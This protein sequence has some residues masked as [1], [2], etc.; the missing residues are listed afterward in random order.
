MGECE[1]EEGEACDYMDNDDRNIDIDVALSYIDDRI[2]DI[3]GQYQKDFEGGVSADTLGARFGGY[4]TFLPTYQRSPSIRSNPVA[5]HKVQSHGIQASSLDDQLVEGA[6]QN[7]TGSISETVSARPEAASRSAFPLRVAKPFPEDRLVKPQRSRECVSGYEPQKGPVNPSNQKMLKVRFKVGSDNCLPELKTSAIYSNLGLDMSPSSSSEDT[8]SPSECERDFPDSLE[9]HIYSPSYIVRIMTSSLIPSGAILSPLHDCLLN[10]SEKR[11]LDHKR[12]VPVKEFSAM[13]ADEKVLVNRQK[14]PANRSDRLEVKNEHC[15]DPTNSFSACSKNES[16]METSKGNH[17]LFD[18]GN[19]PPESKTTKVGKAAVRTGTIFRANLSGAMKELFSQKACKIHEVSA[20]A[21]LTG[22]V[23]KD[24]KLGCAPRDD[25][26]EGDKSHALFK[27]NYMPEGM[28]KCG[29]GTLDPT[30]HKFKKKKSS[31]LQDEMKVPHGKQP[32][33]GKKKPKGSKN[34]YSST[35]GTS[36][37]SMLIRLTAEPKEK[38]FQKICKGDDALLEDLRKVKVKHTVS[39]GDRKARGNEFRSCL[40]GTSVEDE[41]EDNTLEVPEKEPLAFR[42]KSNVNSGDKKTSFVSTSKENLRGDINDVAPL[43]RPLPTEVPTFLIQEDW[44]CCDKCHKWRLLPYGTNP[45]QLPQKWLCSML[46]W[47]PGMNHCT[48]SEEETTDALHALYRLPVAGNHCDQL[49][50]SVS[51][52]S[53]I[54]LV[55]T[56]HDLD[57]NPQ[58]PSFSGGKKKLEMKE[59]SHPAQYSVNKK[60]LNSTMKNE[61]VFIER[62]LHNRSLSSLETKLQKRLGDVQPQKFK[63]MKEADQ[64]GFKHSKKA[65]MEGMQYAVE[66]HNT[67]GISKKEMGSNNKKYSSC[68]DVRYLSKDSTSLNVKKHEF[69]KTMVTEDLD[70][71]GIEGKK[72]KSKD[73]MN[74]Q[75]HPGNHSGNGQDNSISVEETSWSECRKERHSRKCKYEEKDSSTSK[76]V[77]KLFGKEKI[78][79]SSQSTVDGKNSERRDLSDGLQWMAATS[80]SSLI[81]STCKVKINFQDFKDSPVESVCSSPLKISK[82][83]SPRSFSGNHGSTDVGF[84]HFSDQTKCLEGESV[85]VSNWSET[86]RKENAPV[87]ALIKE[88]SRDIYRH[89][90]DKVEEK[91]PGQKVSSFKSLNNSTREDDQFGRE[92]YDATLRKMDAVSQKD[93]KSSVWHNALQNHNNSEFLDLFPSDTINQ[94]ENSAGRQQSLDFLMF[95]NK[96]ENQCWK[97]RESDALEAPRQLGKDDGQN[98]AQD[99]MRRHHLLDASN[100]LASHHLRNDFFSQVA[101]DALE[102]VKDLKQLADPLQ[103]SASGLQIAELFFQAALKFLHGASLFNPDNNS[104][105]NGNMT[106]AEMYSHAAKLCEYCASEFERCNDLASAFLAHKCIE[107]AYMRMVYSNDRT[108]SRDRCEL[109]RALQRV[110]PVKSPSSSESDVENLNSEVKVEKRHITKD[111]GC[112]E[113]A[114]DHVIPA[115]NQHNFV[116]LLNFTEDVNL[117]MEALRKSQASFAAAEIILTETGNSEGVSSIKKV[118]DMGFHDVE[119]LLQL[120]HLAIESLRKTP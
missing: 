27:D 95:G 40:L 5:Q 36:N 89:N 4:G 76:G 7:S 29:D 47:L 84:C 77:C 21:T 46:D 2:Q 52:E 102:G 94:V 69:Q 28:R 101:N 31:H 42:N 111:V 9:E 51:A 65:R 19:H 119:G 26:S 91:N 20:K 15:D 33:T 53:S 32:S 87:V 66:D 113:A 59:V 68:I 108:A 70:P 57:Q 116:R 6:L 106:S 117:A 18:A 110:C 114:R 64:E 71:M 12:T 97:S 79:Y 62:S 96:K 56:L 99:V 109:Q 13:Q 41:T 107:V 50:H 93:C 92:G 43:A 61:Q 49:S 54:T 85:G 24:K 120:V 17:T 39:I 63:S 105:N 22:K 74:N 55:N 11:F 98:G 78:N 25:G 112:S 67:G 10:L 35:A 44:V 73:W 88:K 16:S 115:R 72:R 104:T 30:K 90:D 81:S 75:I 34:D 37:N 58:D 118:L 82:R 8:D 60:Q 45:N 100:I 1:I 80:S 3:L 23:Q 48:F 14:K 83:V 103:I 86:L 38:I